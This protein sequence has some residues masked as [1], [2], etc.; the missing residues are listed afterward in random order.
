MRTHIKFGELGRSYKSGYQ[1][2]ALGP[3]DEVHT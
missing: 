2:E 3:P 1:I